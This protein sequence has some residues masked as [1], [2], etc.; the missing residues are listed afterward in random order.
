MVDVAG[1]HRVTDLHAALETELGPLYHVE[2]EVRPVGNC[3]LFVASNLTEGSELLVKVLPS[4]LSLAVDDQVFERELLLLADRLTDERLVTPRTA[5]RAGA[6]VYHTRRFEAG[7]TLRNW[8][9]RNG[10]LPMRK[11]VQ[12]LRDVL[13]ALSAAH[14]AGIGHGDLKPENI[15][16]AEHQALVADTGVV[17]AV[18]RSLDGAPPGVAVAALCAPPYVAPERREGVASGPVTPGEDLY[19]V[20]VITHEMLASRPPAPESEPLEEIRSV[21]VWLGEIVRRCLAQRPADRWPDANGA[22]SALPHPNNA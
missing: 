16:L 13:S 3:R 11:A 21:P 18:E 1:D 6:F 5:G 17:G 20:G 14:A 10:D 22:L 19:A 15:L 9:T 2:R 12:V 8:I 4:T 7:T